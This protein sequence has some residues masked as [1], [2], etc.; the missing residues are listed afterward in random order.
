MESL[1]LNMRDILLT[2]KDCSFTELVQY[3]HEY[4]QVHG[5]DHTQSHL[6]QTRAP[7]TKVH[8]CAS[9]PV[10][11]TCYRSQDSFSLSPQQE[12]DTKVT[13]DEAS[14]YQTM[15]EQILEDQAA[16]GSESSADCLADGMGTLL[17]AMAQQCPGDFWEVLAAQM[18]KGQQRKKFI[19]F[20]CGKQGHRWLACT[21]LW[22]I[23]KENGFIPRDKRGP[24]K[25]NTPSKKP[26][27]DKN[28]SN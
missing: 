7:G 22:D 24:K 12:P 14:A 19:C 26:Q 17:A 4:D 18:S 3:V 8:R 1:P 28:Q 16:S 2:A 20:F 6:P 21:K 27:T 11:E 23:L 9:E 15:F 13:P 5:N 10:Q 25:A